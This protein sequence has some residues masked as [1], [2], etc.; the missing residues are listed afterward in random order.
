MRADP[1]SWFSLLVERTLNGALSLGIAM[2]RKLL[3]K[4]PPALPAALLSVLAR[5][6]EA[7][8]V[9]E[10]DDLGRRLAAM[11]APASIM[12]P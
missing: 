8:L 3:R 9:L 7:F 6:M 11:P 4:L 5:H 10:G 2:I 1:D 12:E